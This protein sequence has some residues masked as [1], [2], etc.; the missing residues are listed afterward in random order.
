MNERF[1]VRELTSDDSLDDLTRLLHRAFKDLA[2]QGLNVTAA[3]QP[4]ELTQR[5][6]G[7]GICFLAETSG[8]VVGTA[9]LVTTPELGGPPE[10]FEPGVAVLG[11]FAVH[12]A[13]RGQGVGGLLLK[14]VES[15]AV[16]RGFTSLALDT[17]LP[18]SHLL[19]YY[20]RNGFEVVATHQWPGKTYV[21]AVMTKLL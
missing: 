2:V 5:R 12:P 13:R 1:I 19:D 3:N 18:A 20:G 17:P 7:H 4:L 15:S 8:K 16:E 10:F 6:I 9:L 11:Q 14:K 21:S